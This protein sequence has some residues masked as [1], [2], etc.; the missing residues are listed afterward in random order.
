MTINNLTTD[1]SEFTLPD[2]KKYSGSYHVH[3]SKGAMVGATH[4]EAFHKRLT[5]TS[6]EVSQRI[7][8][9]QQ[10]LR[11]EESRKN[12]IKSTRSAT[13]RPNRRTSSRRTSSRGTSGGG[14]GGY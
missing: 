13:R 12:K 1:G 9:I 5:P 7:A 2:G 14:G 11:G 10:Q 4:T 8:S 3:I 6:R